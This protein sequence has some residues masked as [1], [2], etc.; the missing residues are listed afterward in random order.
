[1]YE[2]SRELC[3]LK[4]KLKDLQGEQLGDIRH[5]LDCLKANMPAISDLSLQLCDLKQK[6]DVVQNQDMCEI[7]Q[8]IDCLN[9]KIHTLNQGLADKKECCCP[10]LVRKPSSTCQFCEG[11]KLPVMNSF[12]CE[13]AEAIG[14]RCLSDV[15][16]SIYLRADNIYHVNLRDMR[17]GCSLGC[18]LV[19]DC[20]I[21]EA[22][23]LGVFQKILT[24]C[25]VDVRNTLPPKNCPMGVTFEFHHPERQCG[26]C[27]IPDER[28]NMKGKSLWPGF[29]GYRSIK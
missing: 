14:T 19:N 18:F 1:M 21:E 3:E 16:M 17:T 28:K 27:D 22:R 12:R 13:L 2:M 7:R 15:V 26:G 8:L 20:G 25:V 11:L 29:W 6:F 4:L 10:T 24:F 9:G 23:K 5:Q